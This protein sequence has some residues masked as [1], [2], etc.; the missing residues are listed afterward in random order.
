MSKVER[1]DELR[2]F[3]YKYLHGPVSEDVL[4]TEI[5][6]GNCRLA[7]QDYFYTNYGIY[8]DQNEI[9][10]PRAKNNGLLMENNDTSVFLNN[11]K[12]GDIIYGEK[13][14]TSTGKRVNLDE[15]RIANENEW[16]TGLHLG[17]YMGVQSSEVLS[18]LS[19]N[20]AD[21]TKPVIWHSSFISKGTS[22]WSVDKFCE[23]YKPVIA[24][25]I[26]I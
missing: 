12:E 1:R 24:R 17:V 9:V 10:L 19:Y 6:E 23:Y 21:I 3:S 16:L 5:T 13:I 26:I 18:S 2:N 8:L 15:K 20:E 11:L 25:R 14:K 4:K 22:L 7:V